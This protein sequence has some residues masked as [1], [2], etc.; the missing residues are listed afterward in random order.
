MGRC[1]PLILP[2]GSV[3]GH[4]LQK[5][6]KESGLFLSLSTINFVLLNGR[7]EREAMASP[8]AWPSGSERRFYDSRERKVDG[9]TP[10]QVS[11][12]RP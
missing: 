10:S 1:I 8:A 11:L 5:P 4:K 9:S 3:P 6:S 2:P 12:L 7:V